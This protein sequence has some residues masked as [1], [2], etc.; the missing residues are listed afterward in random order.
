MSEQNKATTTVGQWNN[1]TIGQ[2]EQR[3]ESRKEWEECQD[4]MNRVRWKLGRMGE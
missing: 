3:E 4:I 2:R 1:K